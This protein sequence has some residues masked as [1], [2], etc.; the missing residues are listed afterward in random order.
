MAITARPQ[1]LLIALCGVLAI[2]ASGSGC[3][4]AGDS[5]SGR[6][7][8][9]TDALPDYPLDLH[10]LVDQFG[11]RPGDRKVAVIRSPEIGFDATEKFAP[12]A[13]YEVRR[14]SDGKLMHSGAPSVWHDGQVEASSGDRGWW[15]DFTPVTEPGRYFVYDAERK[16]RSASFAIGPEVYRDVLKAALRMYYYQRSSYPKQTPYAEACWTDE[17]AYLGKD[18]DGQAHDIDDRDNPA[19]VRDVSGGWFDAGDTNKYSTYALQP[20]HQLL[21]AYEQH[22]AIFTDD[23][24]IPESGNGIPDVIDEVR[25]EVDWLKKMQN[26]D[27]S[28]ALKVGNIQFAKTYPPS[29][30]KS[31]RY[32]IASCTS[33]TIAVASIFA[34]AASVYSRFPALKAE[35]LN[36]RS[37]AVAAWKNYQSIDDKQTACDSQVIHS[38]DADLSVE[39]QKAVAA[40]AAIYL[41]AL[42]GDPDYDDYLHAHY[43]E[44]KPYRDIGWSRYNPDQGEALLSYTRLKDAEPKLRDTI[45]DDKRKDMK[46]GNQIY[47]FRPDDDLYR[48]FL[49][50]QQYHWGSNSPR[51]SYGTS[52]LDAITYGLDSAH[53]DDYRQRAAGILHYFHGVNPFGMVY[54]TNMG[55]YGATRS[56][57]AI[58]HLWFWEG[59]KWGNAA[60]DACG[61]PPGYVPGG[62]NVNAVANGVPASLMPP[63]GQPAQKSYRDWNSNSQAPW[64]VTE[65]GIYFQSAYIELLSAFI[66]IDTSEARPH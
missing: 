28:A 40:E 33:S 31:P 32:Y 17:P 65:P 45:L 54:L 49:H 30:D 35:S 13:R 10:I 41:F 60:T 23:V 51:A 25:W 29:R 24:N 58:F 27:G 26:P 34:H 61:P 39:D 37:R 18:Q 3:A 9:V 20:V 57:N 19:K 22:P 8:A 42:T 47:G 12:G 7:P 14:V 36:L 46:A 4:Q 5:A 64:T 2:G 16:R 21:N 48:A 43:R 66:G 50:P 44:L 6:A 38:G 11:Y 52:N 53:A 1:R 62:P 56:A 59:T 15:F 63:A 55:E